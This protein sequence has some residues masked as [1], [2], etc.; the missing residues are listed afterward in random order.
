MQLYIQPTGPNLHFLGYVANLAEHP[1]RS[2]EQV[3]WEFFLTHSESHPRTLTQA[4]A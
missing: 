2:I 4:V 1:G 3:A